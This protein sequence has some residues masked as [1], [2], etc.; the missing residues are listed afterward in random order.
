MPGSPARGETVTGAAGSA[1]VESAPKL[2]QTLC[3]EP[4][5]FVAHDLVGLSILTAA[6][7][8][9]HLEVPAARVQTWLQAGALGGA[10]V[11]GQWRVAAVVVAELERSGRLRGRS[12]HLDSRYRG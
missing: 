5:R 8:A 1:G 12:L 6:E 10:K 7:A 9:A 11:S 3:G 2:A 4:E